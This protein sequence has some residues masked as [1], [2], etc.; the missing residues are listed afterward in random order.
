MSIRIILAL[1]AVAVVLLLVWRPLKKKL[2]EDALQAECDAL[3]GQLISSRAQG[4][5]ADETA[6]IEVALNDCRRRLRDLGIET[7]SVSETLLLE[8]D[9][10][11]EQIRQEWSHFK[12]TDYADILKRGSTRGTI[13][14]IGDELARKYRLA[15]DDASEN[16]AQLSLLRTSVDEALGESKA[17]M[18]C[19]GWRPRWKEIGFRPGSGCDRYFGS[20]EDSPE[21]KVTA[22]RERIYDPLRA[23]REYILTKSGSLYRT[24]PEYAEGIRR[25]NERIARTQ[26]LAEENPEAIRTIAALFGVP[27]R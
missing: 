13:L 25:R 3:E 5:G 20:T 16:A 11:R 21:A 23:S 24:T 15:A 19:Y 1:G 26:R 18:S 9:A 2:E 6:R 14:R 10:A 8:I 7:P 22:E 17:R 12:S 4:T 27:V